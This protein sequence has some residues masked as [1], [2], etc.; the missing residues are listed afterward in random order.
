MC[1]IAAPRR[2]PRSDPR[3]RRLLFNI[4]APVLPLMQ[5]GQL[6][7]LAVTTAQRTP[8]APDLP[9]L[10]EAAL[11]GFD[12][13]GWF[14]FF[15]PA[16]TPPEIVTKIHADTVA[17]LADARDQGDGWKSSACSWS[18]RRRRSSALFSKPRWTNGGR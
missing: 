9:T 15:V 8:A 1:P 7:G 14:A 18:A 13:S 2:A 12:V 17:A 5:Q 16:K 3:T 4:I 10:A 6:R 11:P